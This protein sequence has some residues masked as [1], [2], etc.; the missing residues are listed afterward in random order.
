V[1]CPA[2]RRGPR[3]VGPMRRAVG[4]WREGGGLRGVLGARDNLGKVR[5]PRRRGRGPDAG[6]AYGARR[7]S[8]APRRRVPAA[9]CFTVPLFDRDLLPKFE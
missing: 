2:V 8:G 7:R 4:S 9:I 5:V 3:P 6:V 1:V